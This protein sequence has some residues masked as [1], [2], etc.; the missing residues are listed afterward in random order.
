MNSL[1]FKKFKPAT[2]SVAMYVNQLLAA[3]GKMLLES[4]REVR[5]QR[6]QSV[7]TVDAMGRVKWEQIPLERSSRRR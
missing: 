3:G 1:K 2:S 4:E 7:A 6:L 5:I